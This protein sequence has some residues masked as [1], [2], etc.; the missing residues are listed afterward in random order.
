MSCLQT[1]PVPA[2][3]EWIRDWFPVD[4][5]DLLHQPSDSPTQWTTVNLGEV[6][7]GVPTPLNWAV[8]GSAGECGLRR[9]LHAI[10]TYRES[11]TAIP[12]DVALRAIGIMWGRGVA[13]LDVFRE[14]ADRTPG[15]SGDAMEAQIFGSTQT[16]GSSTRRY[17]RYPFVMLKMPAAAV[18]R[19]RVMLELK[20]QTD[21]W[22]RSTVFAPTL[23]DRLAATALLWDAHDRIV[24]IF[25]PHNVIMMVALAAFM[26]VRRIAA[27]AGFGGLE[28]KLL[29]TGATEESRTVED[30]W[31][32][33]RNRMSFQAF[34]IRHG[35]HG[36][37][38]NEL[39][40]RVWRE[41]PT[42]L[43][44]LISRYRQMHDEASPVL[45][46]AQR[47]EERAAAER[48]LNRKLGPIKRAGVRLLL[49]LA[50]RFVPLREAGRDA[51]L[52]GMDVVRYAARI[53]GADLQ[54]HGVLT[55]ADDAFYLTPIELTELPPGL[56]ELVA[57]R[58]ARRT[59]YQSVEL[60]QRWRGRIAPRIKAAATTDSNVD[61][62]GVSS[63]IA[64]GLVRVV[65]DPSTDELQ[66][67]EI[68]VCRTTD[69][70]WASYFFIAKGV[71]IDVGGALSHGAII[72]RELGL[73]CII[74][75]GNATQQ[76]HTGDRIRIDGTSG[77]VAILERAAR[78]EAS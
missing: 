33:S 3:G 55:Q 37:Q 58:R 47:L 30:L 32:V 6:F 44:N 46:I 36:P 73:P 75:A 29:F 21:L 42:P 19:R 14:F 20:T 53:I 22:W 35:H 12:S 68:L 16:A 61:G 10:G 41:D 60:P 31:A 54:R 59:H 28:S 9:A 62:I 17:G 50:R 57:L 49:P 78:E 34:L 1:I 77:A 67:G 24:K 11:E 66:E 2:A 39:S 15:T 38:E 7:P 45:G 25:D 74:N 76:L 48:A 52:K 18:K 56:R 4:S 70:G 72:A 65:L 51:F 13:N 40:S 26:P 5:L 64:E 69:P 23:P 63:G 43:H 8:L 71:V 27:A